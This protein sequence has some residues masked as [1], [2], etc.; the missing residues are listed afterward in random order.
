[1]VL[2]SRVV[3]LVAPRRA[4]R[5]IVD[6]SSE[7]EAAPPLVVNWPAETPRPRV[8]LVQDAGSHAYWTRYRR[9][10][11]TNGFYFRLVDIHRNSWIDMM[12][13][14]DMVVWRPDSAPARLEEA[15]RKIF[16]LNEFL[17]MKT[18]PTFRSVGLYED[19][20]LQAWL[21]ASLGLDTPPTVTSFSRRDAFEGLKELGDDIVWKITTG[22]G[23]CGVELLNARQASAATRRA[24]STRGR[25]TYWPYVNQKGY[26]Y[27]QALQRDL[28]TDMRITV[29][30]PLFFGFYRDAPPKDFRASGMGRERMEALPHDALEQAWRISREVALGPV[31][32]DFLVDRDLR[33]RKVTELSGFTGVLTLDQ[34]HVDGR[35]G[36]Y[37]RRA[38]GRFEFHQGR[39]WVQELALA[40]ALG[41]ACGVD[42]DRLLL[43]AVLADAGEAAFLVEAD[44][45]KKDGP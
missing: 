19:K 16:Y 13:G 21:F 22:S 38:P 45:E 4:E 24:F 1:M 5:R 9:F 14:L 29:I 12:D 18:Y 28:R 15:R 34:L 20:L 41:L 26:V 42:T 7:L 39:Y 25:R 43:E 27:A 2:R 35:P 3:P 40:E 17:G 31:A 6:D 32:V 37:I 44:R 33:Q 8:G 23:S 11:E 36:V 10:L 30:G